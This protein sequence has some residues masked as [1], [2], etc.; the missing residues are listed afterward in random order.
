[1]NSAAPERIAA[2]SSAKRDSPRPVRDVQRDVVEEGQMGDLVADI[3]PGGRRRRGPLLFV[4]VSNEV[5]E[6]RL[7]GGKVIDYRRIHTVPSPL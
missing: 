6:H 1:M 7:L 4:Q 3:P 2:S 5:V